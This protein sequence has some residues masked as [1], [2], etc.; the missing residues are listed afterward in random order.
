MAGRI[1]AVSLRTADRRRR[2]GRVTAGLEAGTRGQLS[3]VSGMIGSDSY[4][5]DRG[6]WAVLSRRAKRPDDK[7]AWRPTAG[8]SLSVE[9]ASSPAVIRVAMAIGPRAAAFNSTH[10]IL[11]ST[12]FVDAAAEKQSHLSA[13]ARSRVA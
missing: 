1:N 13:R 7:P 5:D 9:R 8:V 12:A 6:P 11:E 3:Q 2:L 10:K 4:V